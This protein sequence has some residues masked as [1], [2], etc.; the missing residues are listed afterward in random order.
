MK[1]YELHKN[2]VVELEAECNKIRAVINEMEGEFNIL[3]GERGAASK[4]MSDLYAKLQVADKVLKEVSTYLAC[5][6]GHGLAGAVSGSNCGCLE[7]HFMPAQHTDVP[8]T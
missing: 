2:E 8:C 7:Q 6:S 3:K 5:P 1:E 4:I